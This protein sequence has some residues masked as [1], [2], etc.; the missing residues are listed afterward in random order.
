MSITTTTLDYD[1]PGNFLA[2]DWKLNPRNRLRSDTAPTTGFSNVINS[3][4]MTSNQGAIRVDNLTVSTGASAVQNYRLSISI[5]DDV[6]QYYLV[7]NMEIPPYSRITLIDKSSQILLNSE[8][9]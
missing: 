2:N 7:H 9:M 8:N 1:Y 6:G 5:G 4:D 3:S